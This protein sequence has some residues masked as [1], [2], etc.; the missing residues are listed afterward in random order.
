[1]R[2][3]VADQDGRDIMF[4]PPEC[5]IDIDIGETNDF[6]LVI[7]SELYG[8]IRE[9]Y[10]IYCEGTEYGGRLDD[11]EIDTEN[12]TVTFIGDSFRAMLSKS[13]ICPPAGSAYRTIT[14]KPKDCINFAISKLSLFESEP[15]SLNTDIDYR[16][17][18]YCTTLDGLEKMAGSIGGRLNISA[19]CDETLK[20][21]LSIEP[22][23]DLSDLVELSQDLGVTFTLKE[24]TNLY[25]HI[26]A[27][28]A[29]SLTDRIVLYGRIDGKDITWLNSY[30]D[31]GTDAMVYKYDYPNED[32]V[33]ELK[34]ACIELI[35]EINPESEQNINLPEEYDVPIGQTIGARDYITGKSIKSRVN[36]KVIKVRDGNL[37]YEFRIG[38]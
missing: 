33:D 27:L 11:P 18:R 5:E 8:R 10:Y 14:G 20:V 31:F 15:G 37:S 4:L 23:E 6:E 34:K 13:I 28:G 21:Y 26:I 25:T 19:R 9:K 32:K 35:E 12:N 2:F 36:G 17:D 7:P 22:A 24:K 38:G 1:M 16:F 3:I 29:G 30:D